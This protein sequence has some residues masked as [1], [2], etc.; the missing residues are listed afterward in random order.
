M[1]CVLCFRLLPSCLVNTKPETA[2]LE[3]AWG[4]ALAD[5]GLLK[6]T[7]TRKFIVI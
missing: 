2:V 6:L 7:S 3:V 4:Q 1:Y 5:V